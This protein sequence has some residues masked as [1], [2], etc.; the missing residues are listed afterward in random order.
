MPGDLNTMP[1]TTGGGSY[2]LKLSDSTGAGVLAYGG[3]GARYGGTAVVTDS[4][5]TPVYLVS[6]QV[7][8]VSVTSLSA[9]EKQ[10]FAN[11]STLAVN[12]P[13]NG[14]LYKLVTWFQRFLP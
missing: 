8:Q 12:S 2:M 3:T 14:I 13:G 1:A 4:S 6:D 7:T 11:D 10:P 9:A 5:G